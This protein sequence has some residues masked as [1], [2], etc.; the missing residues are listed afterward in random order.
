MAPE[1]G[2]YIIPSASSPNHASV[3]TLHLAHEEEGNRWRIG[4]VEAAKVD[5]RTAPAD[6]A[7]RQRLQSA[8]RDLCDTWG[9]ALT[10]EA[11]LART[12]QRAD[13]VAFALNAMRFTVNA[14]I[15]FANDRAF[16]NSDNF[17][18]TDRLTFADVYTIIPFDNPLV[19]LRLTGAELKGV[20]GRLGSGVVARGLA[21][22]GSQVTINGRPI[23][24]DRS[25]SVVTNQFVADGGDDILGED[26][27]T[28][29]RVFE[30]SWS[31]ETPS[32]SD[33][34]V[35]FVR[36]GLYAE[37]GEV[38]D[39]LSPTGNFPD[40][41]ERFLWKLVGSLTTSYNQVAVRNPPADEG[42]AY[43]QSQLNV[44]ST[45]QINLEGNLQANADSRN[46]GWDNSLLLQY[47]TTRINPTEGGEYEET[48]DLI[49]GKSAYKYAGFHSRSGGRW[50]APWPTVEVQVE[51]EFDRPDERGWHK[52]EVTTIAGSA[53]RLVEPLEIKLGADLRRDLNDP[54]GEALFGLAV[55]YR[56]N[57]FDLFDVGGSPVQFE[58]EFEYFFN[59]PGDRN[60]HEL[61][62]TSRL[63]Y[64]LL[65]RLHVTSTFSAFAFR[66]GAVGSFGTN[67]EFTLGLN[68]L[69]DAS[70]QT[71]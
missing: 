16:L 5:T 10:D 53:F 51:S 54:F 48:K 25:Y 64:S 59:D 24:E 32:V 12:F 63:F 60:L 4:Q 49:R 33:V 56:L 3:S 62:T 11:P 68:Y 45:N 8:A 44:E 50:W 57:R 27:G 1:T 52:L 39:R 37:R 46:H 41:H 43:D 21:K 35:R 2:T 61:R 14:E 42:P 67:T 9:D 47:A 26:Q 28:R 29:R 17:P 40:L 65:D 36:G 19:R 13:F 66:S 38:T 31:E 20:A 7:T 70:F 18:L 34:V 23:R 6:E 55:A 71:F 22:S 30:P 69:W 15:A 58:S